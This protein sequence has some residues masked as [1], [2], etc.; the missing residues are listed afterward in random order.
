[1]EA[2]YLVCG[3]RRSQLKRNP[4]GSG[5]QPMLDARCLRNMT[6][7]APLALAVLIS[8]CGQP[9]FQFHTPK[10]PPEPRFP[11]PVSAATIHTIRIA[12]SACFGWCPQYSFTLRRNGE[13]TY[14]GLRF[15]QLL[16]PYRAQVD[17]ASFER[18]ATLVLRNGFFQMRSS[19]VRPITDQASVT[20]D[21]MLPDTSKTVWDY[22]HFGPESLW[23]IQSAIDSVGARLHWSYMADED[24]AAA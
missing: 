11:R 24:C 15:V 4:L 5:A 13:A 3:A 7:P 16:G 6:P 17:T 9:F 10:P 20:I 14:C 18:L 2:I 23:E 21:A 8:A 1:M 22:G 12:H 19:Y